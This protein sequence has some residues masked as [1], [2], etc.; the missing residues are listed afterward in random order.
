MFPR[1][2]IFDYL[3][4]LLIELPPAGYAP[5]IQAC[6][7]GL[8]RLIGRFFALKPG[9][10]FLR[11]VACLGIGGKGQPAIHHCL[12]HLWCR[13]MPH[14]FRG[15]HPQRIERCEFGCQ[16]RILLD[17]LGFNCSSIQ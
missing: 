6:A 8:A 9:Y 7:V 16:Y 17:I 11:G 15:A 1:R 2:A 3:L 13:V 5:R 4:L 14:K 10:Q 12:D